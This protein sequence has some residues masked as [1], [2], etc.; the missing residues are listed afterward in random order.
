MSSL[1]MTLLGKW[2]VSFL[3]EIL[4]FLVIDSFSRIIGSTC[5][6]GII[7]KEGYNCVGGF[8]SYRV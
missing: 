8:Y 1:R 6:T 2:R 3:R 5:L 4:C 7:I